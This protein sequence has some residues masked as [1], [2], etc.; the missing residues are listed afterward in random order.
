M[1]KLLVAFLI[2]CIS[3]CS[4]KTK[5]PATKPVADTTKE[6][7]LPVTEFLLG[8]LRDLDSIQLAPLKIVTVNGKSD[9]TWMKR[10]DIRVFVQPFLHPVIDTANLSSLFSQKSFLDQTLHAYTFTYDPKGDLPDSLTLNH[11][12][13]YIDPERN[14]FTRIY[15]VKQKTTD[16]V[17]ETMQL[18]WKANELAMITTIKEEKG[19]DPEIR[20][21]KLIWKF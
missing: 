15:M 19:K 20:E 5:T 10:E 3:G 11:W 2:I 1:Q 18:T 7:F 8:E 17:T 21:E 12:D 13:V 14:R 6:K 16:D 9:S 4:N